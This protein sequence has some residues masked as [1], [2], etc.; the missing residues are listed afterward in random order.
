MDRESNAKAFK[1]AD[2][3]DVRDINE[4]VFLHLIRDR[5]PIS[6]A[7]LS[8]F[9]GLRAGTVSAI[10]NR[11][12]KNDL[13][14]E[15]VEGPSSGG[16]PPKYLHINADSIYVLAIDIGVID[17][18]CAVSDFNGRIL[19]RDVIKTEGRPETFFEDLCRRIDKLV[20]EGQLRERLRAVGVSVPGLIDRVTGVLS[21]SPNLEW[22]DVPI[23][24]IL[25]KHCDLPVFV[26][27]DAN[28]AAFSELWYGPLSEAN[29][30]TL[31]Y[32]LVVEGLGTGLIINGQLHVGSRHGLGGFGHMSIDPKGELCSCGRR[33]CWETVASE[34]ATV[35]R[36]HRV[37]AKQGL[38]MLSLQGIIDLAK[39]GDPM[40]VESLKVTGEYLGQGVSNLVHGIYPEAVVIGGAITEAWDL[41]EPLITK[42]LAS[43]YLESPG[44]VT[45]RPAS[46]ERPSLYGAIPIAFRNYFRSPAR[47]LLR[48]PGTI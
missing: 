13:V 3:S 45:V 11:L 33:G 27:N 34:R 30:R 14:Y 37:T 38:P 46:V 39:R 26:E 9:T 7:D 41:I 32:I 5:Q 23:R 31:L 40:A 15:G 6:R 42:E 48:A 44:M 8:K 36:Y 29:I 47:P 20:G 1:M 35:E 12:I 17:T 43:K 24:A 18:V 22:A 16:R 25:E 21:V 28:A 2:V 10:V 4:T 19:I